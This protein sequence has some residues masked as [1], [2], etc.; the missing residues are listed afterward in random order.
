M[1]YNERIEQC[2]VDMVALQEQKT[3]LL[4]EQRDAGGYVWRH[5]DTAVLS[6]DS[7]GKRLII[8]VDD[9]L[10]IFD[11][12]NGHQFHLSRNETAQKHAVSYKYKKTGNIFEDK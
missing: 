10:V 5:G 8:L 2:N 4:K 7:D 1:D 9:Q 3:K 6:N 12:H 11:T